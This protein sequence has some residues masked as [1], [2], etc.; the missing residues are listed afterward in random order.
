MGVRHLISPQQS[1][2]MQKTISSLS[3]H[4]GDHPHICPDPVCNWLEMKTATRI[5]H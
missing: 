1:A 3:P 4:H 2:V 5:L